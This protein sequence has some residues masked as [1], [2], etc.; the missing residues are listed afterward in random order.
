MRLL[1][2]LL[3]FPVL[4]WIEGGVNIDIFYILLFYFP[5]AGPAVASL[6]RS[7][8]GG[9]CVLSTRLRVCLCAFLSHSKDIRSVGD[10]KLAPRVR[11][12]C[13]CT[14]ACARWLQQPP[15]PQTEV[16]M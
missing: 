5:H 16:K 15:R 2:F 3:E 10:L 8:P 14:P 11:K 1:T 6:H 7:C 9:V 4:S 12:E 13:A